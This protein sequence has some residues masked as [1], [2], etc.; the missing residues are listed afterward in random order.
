[1]R[2]FLLVI[3]FFF[4]IS[5]GLNKK[6]DEMKYYF[7][8]HRVE[9]SKVIGKFSLELNVTDEKKINIARYSSISNK[10]IISAKSF[11]WKG[12]FGLDLLLKP[13]AYNNW[14]QE[15]GR[16]PHKIVIFLVEGQYFSKAYYDPHN[17][18]NPV[19]FY[20]AL[21]KQQADKIS[22]QIQINFKIIEQQKK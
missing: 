1:M 6:K 21:P 22:K 2:K 5:C 9:E 14:L 15:A 10:D 8:V 16:D 4:I 20:C 18:S 11:K 17:F 7:T 13:T 3:F 19:R 12:G